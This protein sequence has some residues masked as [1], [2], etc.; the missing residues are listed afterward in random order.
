MM[1]IVSD[2]VLVGTYCV[3]VMNET[4]SGGLMEVYIQIFR[5]FL[6]SIFYY[7]FETKALD[8][9]YN[10]FISNTL[11]DNINSVSCSLR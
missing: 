3:L 2:E 4:Y 11:K 8:F 5:G 9:K 1:I 6:F 10:M 7:R